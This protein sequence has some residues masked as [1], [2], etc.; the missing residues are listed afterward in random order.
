VIVAPQALGKAS[1]ENTP[2]E[3]KALLF[4]MDGTLAETESLAHRVA[5]NLTFQ[6]LGLDIEWTPELYREL[7]RAPGGGRERVVHFRKH[8]QPD[9]GSYAN[10]D[11]QEW[12]KL[13]HSGK[14][15][16]FR[17]L[18]REGR[19]PLR[20]GVRRLFEELVSA[21]INV[22]IVTNASHQTVAPVLRYALG[23]RLAHCVDF[24]IGAE[25]VQRK[26]PQPDSYLLALEKLKLRACDCIAVEDSASGLKAAVAAGLTTLVVQNQDTAGEDFS[27]AALVVD[28]LGEPN[29]NRPA[30][31]VIHGKLDE[32]CVTLQTLRRLLAESQSS[33]SS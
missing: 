26:K 18:L 23:E 25:S 4:D 30:P 29:P 11:P 17:K 33:K 5:Y 21:G 1:L 31:K 13:V 20:A 15:R 6:E 22:C 28:S 8:Y 12:A 14:S 24:V 2:A 16:H 3:L 7:L 19:L 32:P 27:A 9:L 10:S